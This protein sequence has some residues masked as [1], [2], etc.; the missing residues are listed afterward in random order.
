MAYQ[1]YCLKDPENN[2][3][4]YVGFTSN[5]EKIRFNGH[6]CDKSDTEKTKWIGELRLNGKRPILEVI[7]KYNNIDDARIAEKNMIINLRSSGMKLTNL[8]FGRDDGKIRKPWISGKKHS[9]ETKIKMSE[10]AKNRSDEAKENIRL[11]HI[12]PSEET[13]R[14]MSIASSNRSEETRRKMSIARKGKVNLHSEKKTYCS[15]GMVFDSVKKAADALSLKAGRIGDVCRGKQK[16]T[17]GLK[18]SY[19]KGFQ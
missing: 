19:S 10:R 3:I 15:N 6:F 18:F 2:Q 4:K 7:E 14:K 12:N 17:G 13:R 8:T 11:A 9:E 16:T 5:D 1:L